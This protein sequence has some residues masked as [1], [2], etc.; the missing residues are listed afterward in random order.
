MN[1][2]SLLRSG[3]IQVRRYGPSALAALLMYAGI[4]QILELLQRDLCRWIVALINITI[5]QYFPAQMSLIEVGTIPWILQAK[6]AAAEVILVVVGM[7]FGLW[8][9]AR[10]RRQPASLASLQSKSP[11]RSEG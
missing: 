8:V 6:I 4:D 9:Q 5:R 7:F 3:L 1:D 10:W 11:R 2:D